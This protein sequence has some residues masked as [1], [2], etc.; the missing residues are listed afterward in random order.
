MLRRGRGGFRT[1]EPAVTVDPPGEAVPPAAVLGAAAMDRDS[2]PMIAR[3]GRDG[4]VVGSRAVTPWWSFTKTLIAAAVMRLIER[5]QTALDEELPDTG[6]TPRGLLL[7]RAGRFICA[8]VGHD[9]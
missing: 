8:R 1:S 5:G 7:H 6:A 4:T 2:I 9:R 3:I